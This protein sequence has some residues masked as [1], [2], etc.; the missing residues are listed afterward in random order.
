MDDDFSV[1]TNCIGDRISCPVVL[2]LLAKPLFF[3]RLS[4]SKA[5]GFLNGERKLD[6]APLFTNEPLPKYFRMHCTPNDEDKRGALQLQEEYFRGRLGKNEEE[7]LSVVE[8]CHMDRQTLSS[9][10]DASGSASTLE[11]LRRR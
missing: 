3:T 4:G 8:H 1:P 11:H 9:H 7:K 2:N 10:E 6:G 5:Q